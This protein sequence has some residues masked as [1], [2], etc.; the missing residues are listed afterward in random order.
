MSSAIVAGDSSL[1]YFLAAASDW[2][3]ETDAGLRVTYVSEQFATSTGVHR[4][5]P[6]GRPL[7]EMVASGASTKAG[8]SLISS[9]E[10]RR[11]FRN[12]VRSFTDQSGRV[13]YTRVNGIP[14]F[15]PD[16]AF[17]GYRG[18][19]TDATAENEAL[20]EAEAARRS[21][22]RAADELS[23]TLRNI[24]DAVV[25]IDA[26]GAIRSCN[27]AAQ[28]MFGYGEGELIGLEVLL[29]AVLHVVGPAGLDGSRVDLRLLGT[30]VG[31]EQRDHHRH[32]RRPLVGLGHQLVEDP[33]QLVEALCLLA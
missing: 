2:F 25:T 27:L 31:G 1:E 21:A 17:L 8:R 32:Q 9:L 7:V 26:D 5:R 10:K 13:R 22:A 12:F 16:G 29:L 19:A 24:A 6:L 30:A 28:H 33:L 11:P 15:A 3:W 14:A 23:A 18:S 4:E 20:R